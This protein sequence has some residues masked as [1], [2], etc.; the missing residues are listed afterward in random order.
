MAPRNR[1]A[2]PSSRSW[3]PVATWY[4]GWV[5]ARGSNHHRQ[6]AIPALLDLLNLL[7]GEHVL[8][9][10]CGPGVLAGEVARLKGRYTGVDASPKLLAFARRHHGSRGQFVLGDATRLDTVPEIRKGAFDAA[11]FLLSIQDIEPLE[12]A[13]SSAAASV[14]RG[15]RIVVLMT[16][17]CFRVPRQSGWGWDAER[18]LQYRRV[19]RYL[20]RLDVPMK[21]Y[22]GGRGTTWSHHRPL[23][24][25]VNGLAAN[26]LFLDRIEEI[27]GLHAMPRSGASPAERMA[28][29]E[30]PLFMGVRAVKR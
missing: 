2:R 26:G 12:H 30:I 23:A 28:L 19:D 18:R 20:T 13:F 11:T 16:H 10:G 15:G 5:G 21:A 7:P 17:P 4:T 6:L 1:H 8:D 22:E 14:R 3:D 29:K 24:D 25:Y 9:V 27:P